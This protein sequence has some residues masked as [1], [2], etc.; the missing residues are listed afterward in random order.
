M[1]FCFKKGFEKNRKILFYQITDMKRLFH[2]L[3]AFLPKWHVTIMTVT[4]KLVVV[5][6]KEELIF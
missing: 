1:F 4:H 6:V 2:S 3:V 5:P